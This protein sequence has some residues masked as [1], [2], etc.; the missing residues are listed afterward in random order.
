MIIKGVT[1][2]RRLSHCFMCSGCVGVL[3]R[4]DLVSSALAA[5]VLDVLL[6]GLAQHKGEAVCGAL[7]RCVREMM[8]G[9]MVGGEVVDKVLA[10]TGRC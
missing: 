5:G 3:Q 10:S 2:W 6:E 7:A 8:R 1:A 4:P 9:E